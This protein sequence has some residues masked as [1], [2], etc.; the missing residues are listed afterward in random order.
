MLASGENN[1]K[2]L[3]TKTQA[4]ERIQAE[5]AKE[6]KRIRQEMHTILISFSHYERI[7]VEIIEA[8]GIVA[9]RIQES[10]DR[11]AVLKTVICLTWSGK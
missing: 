6:E 11:R 5:Y 2:G 3:R 9:G 8:S 4:L 10:E 1:Q 7:R